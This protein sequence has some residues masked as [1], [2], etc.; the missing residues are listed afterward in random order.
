MEDAYTAD[1]TIG[2]NNP[3]EEDTRTPEQKRVDDLM[4]AANTWLATCKEITDEAT[5]K[6]CDDFLQQIKDEADALEE[7]RR[8]FNAPLE[9][10]VKDNNAAYKPLTALLDKA[11][12]LL[13]P[14]KTKW[15]QRE[16]DRLAAEKAAAEKLAAKKLAEAEEAKKLAATS[17]Q[18]AVKADEAIE[19][20]E[21]AA[22]AATVAAAKK[23]QVKGNY[24]TKASSLRTYWSAVITDY[25]LAAN[26]YREHQ[27]VRDLIQSLADADA[28]EHKDKLAIPGVEAKSEER[29]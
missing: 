21:D 22:N 10:Q 20:A 25:P 13:T 19:Q 6:A 5:A 24:A 26:H 4:A 23:A 1:I 12:L 7:A 8:A 11:K 18:A 27:K 16:R 29:A 15:L 17:I 3:P 28:R 9:K 2:H 14:L